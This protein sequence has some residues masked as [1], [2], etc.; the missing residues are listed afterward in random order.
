MTSNRI[1][2]DKPHLWKADI[3][4]SVDGFVLSG[5]RAGEVACFGDGR[6]RRHWMWPE[7]C[8]LVAGSG[9]GEPWRGAL[10]A[11]GWMPAASAVGELRP[12]NVALRFAN[13]AVVWSSGQ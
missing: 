4:A 10:G 6:W 1:N 8:A 12:S 7:A 5:P 3:A 9:A 11:R 13:H 2:A